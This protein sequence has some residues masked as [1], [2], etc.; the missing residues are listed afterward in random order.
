MKKFL[1]GGGLQCSGGRGLGLGVLGSAGCRL[2]S[3][4]VPNSNADSGTQRPW[5]L[6]DADTAGGTIGAWASS[7]ASSGGLVG[8]NKCGGGGYGGD[9][10][11]GHGGVDS[12][13]VD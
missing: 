5:L 4:R 3:N 6:D 13:D 10:G 7:G 9:L 12:V 2:A 1:H 8:G 11:F